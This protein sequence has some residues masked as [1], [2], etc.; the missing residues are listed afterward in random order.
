MTKHK[1]DI[2]GEVVV[3]RLKG[4]LM[5]GPESAEVT[6]E[7]KN[8]IAAGK[9]KFVIDLGEVE[10]MNSSG[11]GLLIGGLSSIRNAG[12]SLYLARVT[13]KIESL[14]VITKL[15][16]V[17]DSVASIEEALTKV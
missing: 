5:G 2:F 11:L 7:L 12:G 9:K 1:T 14:L 3:L 15:S 4:K 6:E 13:D 16:S 10:W 17:F 8:Q